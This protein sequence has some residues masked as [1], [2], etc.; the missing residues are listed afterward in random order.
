MSDDDAPAREPWVPPLPWQAAWLADRLRDRGRAHHAYL[1]AGPAGLGK[2]GLALNLA[3][4][5]LCEAPREGGLACGACAGCGYVA[6]GTHPDLRVLELFRTDRDTGERKPVQE[7]DVEQVRD[8]VEMMQVSTHRRG[9]RVAVIVPAERMNASAANAL[10]KTLEEP[11]PGTT[12]LLVSH[13]PGRLMPTVTSRCLRVPAPVPGTDEAI[14]WLR[15]QG[16]AEPADVLAEAGGAPMAALALAEPGGRAERKA[17]YDA[18]ARPERL[19][20]IALGAR[21][22][23]GGKDE[24]RPRLAVAVDALARWTADL[25]RVSAGGAPQRLPV[26]AAALASLAPK[27]ARIGLCRYHRSVL[28]Q[29]ARLAHPLQPRLV[30]EA[31]L[32]DY[33]ALFG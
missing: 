29:R 22:E 6:A 11:P 9:G 10:L 12:L 30:A 21:I 23:S 13:Q 4:A 15:S 16:V 2:K 28:V 1:I 19:A 18:F 32:A 27:V 7:I 24:R 3:Q 26:H 20:P 31:L 17:W 14:A 8:L 5:L 25:A 33:R